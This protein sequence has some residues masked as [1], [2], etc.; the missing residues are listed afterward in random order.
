[1]RPFAGAAARAGA[2]VASWAL[3]GCVSVD[4][5]KEPAAQV[6]LSLRDLAAAPVTRRAEPLV[7][8]LLVQPQPGNSLADTQ[9][10]AFSRRANEYGF[11]QFAT[12]TDRPV[13]Q[14]PRLL[15]QRLDARGTAAA[16][17]LAGD[18][19]RADWLLAVAVDTLHHDVSTTPGSARVGMTLELF[20]RR[21]RT[22]VSRKAFVAAAPV[23]SAD[24]AAAAK[25]MSAA[26][27]QVIDEA[28]PWVEAELA[29]AAGSAR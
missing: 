8:A 18:P 26:V 6:L 29:R 15:Q 3:V 24:S 7:S 12:W 5:G 11:Y 21:V 23:E 17:A 27:A 20:D 28:V 25:A 1:M 9:Q 16:V 2:L 19:Q 13:R 22:R 10:I 14:I 4:V